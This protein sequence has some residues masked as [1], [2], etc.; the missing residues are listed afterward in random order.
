MEDKEIIEIEKRIRF[1]ESL[2]NEFTKE[3]IISYLATKLVLDDYN[4]EDFPIDIPD[5]M[6]LKN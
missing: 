6:K 4:I 5:D 3:Q 1:V 2:L